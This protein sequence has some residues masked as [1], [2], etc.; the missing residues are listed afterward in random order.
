MNPIKSPQIPFCLRG[1]L[2]ADEGRAPRVWALCSPGLAALGG[3]Q[4]CG[5]SF[6]WWSL[7]WAKRKR[8]RLQS[9]FFAICHAGDKE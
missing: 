5:G 3:P 2:F 9:S 1:P 6:A 7:F 8:F 4:I